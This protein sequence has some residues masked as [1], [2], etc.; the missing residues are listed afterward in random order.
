MVTWNKELVDRINF[1]VFPLLCGKLRTVEHH[2]GVQKTLDESD[3][4]FLSNVEFQLILHHIA[5]HF[6][7]HL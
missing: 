5:Q 3:T 1:L 2:F 4:A 6:G 7:D